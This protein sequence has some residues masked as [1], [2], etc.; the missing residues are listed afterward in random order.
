MPRPKIIQAPSED[1]REVAIG[2]L[3]AI[4]EHDRNLNVDETVF[5]EGALRACQKSLIR[6]EERNTQAAAAGKAVVF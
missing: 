3:T 5:I 4:L 2:A 6:D 1:P